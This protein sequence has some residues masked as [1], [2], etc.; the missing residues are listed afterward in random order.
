[1]ATTYYVNANGGSDSNNGLTVATAFAT[2]RHAGA[3]WNGLAAANQPGCAILV[4]PGVY[5]ETQVYIQPKT[6]STGTPLTIQP[7]YSDSRP[8]LVCNPTSEGGVYIWSAASTGNTSSPYCGVTLI[9][10]EVTDGTSGGTM[11]EGISI[12]HPNV[13]IDR[14]YIHDTG[15]GLAAST[16]GGGIDNTGYGDGVNPFGCVIKRCLVLHC[17]PTA[18]G[19][20]YHG[21][22]ASSYGV[23][24]ESCVTGGILGGYGI[25]GYHYIQYGVI[26]N[27]TTFNCWAGGIV[28][29]SGTIASNYNVI[30]NNICYKNGGWVGV[31]WGIRTQADPGGSTDFNSLIN[32]CCYGNTS[33][34][35]LLAGAHDTNVGM[36]TSDP[37]FTNYASDGTGNYHLR[38]GSPC[39]AAANS[40]YSPATDL[41][42][43]A[44][45][46]ALGYDIGA[47]AFYANADGPMTLVIGDVVENLVAGSMNASNQIG[48]RSTGSIQVWTALGVVWSYGTEVEIYDG[49]NTLVYAGFTTKDKATKRSRQG[50]GYLEHA[51]DLMDNCYKADKRVVFN[52]Y[53]DQSAGSIVRDLFHR[54]LIQE[55]VT[56]KPGSIAAGATIVEVVW[57]GKQVSAALDWLA[58]QSGYWW[59]IDLNGVLWFQPYGGIPAPFKIDGTQV[60]TLYGNLAVTN[61]NDQYVNKQYAKGAYAQQGERTET[62]HGDGLRRNFTLSYELASSSAK[63]LAISVNG[64]AQTFNTKGNS[65]AQWYAAIGDAVIAQ[66]PGQGVLGSGDTL[67]VSYKGRYPVLA[68]ASNPTLIAAQKTREGGGSGI[69]ENVYANT[70]VHSLSAAFQIASGLLVHYGQDATQLEFD[71]RQKGF[72]AGQAVSV[73][74]SDF[75]LNNKTMLV[76][77]VTLTDSTDNQTVW[78][79]IVAIG[80]PLEQASWT[81]YFQNLMNQNADPSDLSDTTDTSLAQLFDSTITRTPTA[82]ITKLITTCPITN[83]GTLCGT[84]VIVC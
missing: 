42:G 16:V 21:I 24:V 48:Q 18:G 41:A 51:L 84:G 31:G 78:W 75:A 38:A 62:F 36:I 35:T 23:V 22:Y 17:G 70:K 74:L 5:N 72:A 58:T 8:T 83:T 43:V 28:V 11:A 67:S 7:L 47:Y 4:A 56:T 52:S 55:G 63:E 14:C 81:T 44:W 15:N 59:Q 77:S 33:A 79:K 25:H 1:M 37:L 71:T 60:D 26:E 9:G 68:V 45:P 69:V 82:T 30:A 64:S 65:G 27:N 66:D 2:C 49:L 46:T 34:A 50:Q 12:A 53:L 20:Q 80:S 32:N 57:N 3:V 40:A 29:G 76:Q 39:I 10:F 54:V 61:G 73:S 6:G 13:T 19:N